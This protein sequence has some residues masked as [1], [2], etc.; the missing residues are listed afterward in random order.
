MDKILINDPNVIEAYKNK[1]RSKKWEE[2]KS[3][4]EQKLK[5][6]FEYRDAMFQAD[7]V[8]VRNMQVRLAGMEDGQI[9]IWL[10]SDNQPHSFG[11]GDIQSMLKIVG[12]RG[13][14][15]YAKSWEAK[16]VIE[17]SSNPADINVLELYEQKINEGL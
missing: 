13:D 8:S 12:D 11:D 9:I 17:N 6:D 3:I 14:M 4:R 2:L 15:L 5:E 1:K 10:D 7:D 16:E